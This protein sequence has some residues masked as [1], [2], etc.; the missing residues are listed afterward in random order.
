MPKVAKAVKP[1]NKAVHR[2][3]SDT[4]V[5]FKIGA[6]FLGTKQ[7]RVRFKNGEVTTMGEG[8]FNEQFEIL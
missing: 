6:D 8:W 2:H 7:Y 4:I 1:S 5:T 3:F